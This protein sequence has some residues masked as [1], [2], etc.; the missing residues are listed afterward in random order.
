MDFYSCNENRMT[1]AYQKSYYPGVGSGQKKVKL[2]VPSIIGDSL[3]P[4]RVGS[5][6]NWGVVVNLSDYHNVLLRGII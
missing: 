4:G 6:K 2:F 1:P 5:K 3:W